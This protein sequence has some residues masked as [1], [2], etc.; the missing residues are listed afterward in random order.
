MKTSVKYIPNSGTS[1]EKTK[2]LDFKKQ[3]LLII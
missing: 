2:D 3:N 1:L